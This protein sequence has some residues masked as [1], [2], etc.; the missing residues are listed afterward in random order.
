MAEVLPQLTDTDQIAFS[1]GLPLPIGCFV[2]SWQ[3]LSEAKNDVQ[4]GRIWAGIHSRSA[5]AHG[6]ELGH[7]IADSAPKTQ[8]LSAAR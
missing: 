5:D 4:G 2:R 6:I 1:A 3:S 7:A 8:M